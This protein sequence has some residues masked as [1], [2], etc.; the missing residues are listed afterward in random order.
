MKCLILVCMGIGILQGA[1]KSR[2]IVVTRQQ[3]SAE[4]LLCKY[5]IAHDSDSLRE[6]FSLFPGKDILPVNARYT[7]DLIVAYARQY[8]NQ[9]LVQLVTSSMQFKKN[10]WTL[11]SLAV[12]A[13][14][15]DIIKLLVS[16]GADLN[17]QDDLGWTA[18]IYSG[19]C[20][21]DAMLFLVA[22]GC[23]DSLKTTSGK[24]VIDI[25]FDK[26][27]AGK[28]IRKGKQARIQNNENVRRIIQEQE[29]L[30]PVLANIIVEYMYGPS[31]KQEI[32]KNKSHCLIM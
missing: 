10:G 25:A 27:L 7:S 23:D 12:I 11:L 1:Q 29:E 6:M 8:N 19:C 2:Q 24:S 13:R 26:G 20:N 9:L 16:H 3:N 28:V 4:T 17:A 32:V 15:A 22:R 31:P 21:M 30:I 5:V 18:L 14:Y